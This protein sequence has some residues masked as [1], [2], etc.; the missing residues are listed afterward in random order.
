VLQ[1][2]ISVRGDDFLTPRLQRLW[3]HADKKAQLCA[4]LAKANGR[5]PF[6]AYLLGLMHDAAWSAVLRGLAG[7][8]GL[9]AWRTSH[10]LFTAVALRRDRL[11]AAIAAH[12]QLAGESLEI[13]QAVG[14]EGLRQVKSKP[15]LLLARADDLASLLC[16]R[17]SSAA[18]AATQDGLLNDSVA[19]VQSL[20]VSLQEAQAKLRPTAHSQTRI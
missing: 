18:L 13:A 4:A 19:P 10:N 20:F 7:A 14:R 1:P 17:G 3:L 12:W 16:L 2:L 8:P 5:E 9:A 15:A 6:D 11:F